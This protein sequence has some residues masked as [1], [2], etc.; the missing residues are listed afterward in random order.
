[1]Y[2]CRSDGLRKR[3]SGDGICSVRTTGT[4]KSRLRN[5]V[6]AT[7]LGLDPEAASGLVMLR[8]RRP[9]ASSSPSSSSECCPCID[10]RAV[11]AAART[12]AT[13]PSFTMTPLSPS[14]FS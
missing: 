4:E 1:M 13:S 3:S 8:R 9:L 6:D 11:Q 10:P 5:G 12:A 7:E 14:R 2:V